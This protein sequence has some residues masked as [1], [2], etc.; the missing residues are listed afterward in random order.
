MI[1]LRPNKQ[2]FSACVADATHQSILD[3][4]PELQPRKFFSPPAHLTSTQIL[5]PVSICYRSQ[6]YSCSAG[7][8]NKLTGKKK[9][10]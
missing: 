10:R 6:H 1:S 5:L 7:T 9:L 8:G 2:Y 3:F 4:L